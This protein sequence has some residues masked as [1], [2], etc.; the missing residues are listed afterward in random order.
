MLVTP[1]H[2]WSHWSLLKSRTSTMI[3]FTVYIISS[4]WSQLV[5]FVTVKASDLNNDGLDVY[6]DPYG[7]ILGT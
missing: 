1:D 4:Y 6:F 5:T 3:A 2:M 7:I